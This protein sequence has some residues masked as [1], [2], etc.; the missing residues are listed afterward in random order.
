MSVAPVMNPNGVAGGRSDR[1]KRM[2]V[3]NND[4]MLYMMDQTQILVYLPY[5]RFLLKMDLSQTANVL[6]ALLL[7]RASLFRK[8]GWKDE[9]GSI[10][11]VYPIGY[12]ADDLGK[13]HMTVKKALNELEE[14]GLL[15]RKKQGFSKP[16][17]LYVK[18][19][20]EGKKSFPV[21][22]R[23][24][25][26]KG[27]ENDTYE[28]KKPVPVMDRK[29]SPNY[30]NN[31]YLIYSQTNKEREAHS[32]YGEYHNVFL[33]ETEYGEL[34]QEIRELDRLIEELSN[35]MRSSGKQY[36]D[37]AVTL[38]RWEERSVP[39]K[40]FRIIPVVRWMRTVCKKEMKLILI[41]GG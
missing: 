4:H 5:P 36:A 30:L 18:I 20:A 10:F 1:Y 13:S 34:K 14:A 15:V 26:L 37:H 28:G 11:V 35:Y 3:K 33:S 6:Y 31:S 17:L 40:T 39:I 38:R 23:K 9:E 22:D 27:K 25:S 12:L 24:V 29:V 32:A 21:K 41:G 2:D 16:N 19:P 7:D 8:T